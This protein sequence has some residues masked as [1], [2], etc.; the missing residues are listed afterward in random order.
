M[1]EKLLKNLKKIEK[2]LSNTDLNDAFSQIKS[3]LDLLPEDEVNNNSL[4]EFVI[5][6][7]ISSNPGS[8]VIYSDGACRGN[9]GPGAYGCIAQDSEA[10]VVFE[11]A[12]VSEQTTNNR[13][14]L[15][16]VIEGITTLG[17]LLN[18][19]GQ[20]ISDVDILVVTDSKYVVDGITKWMD[21]WKSRG[22]RKA[23]KKAPENVE[24]WQKLDLI[25]QK[26]GKRLS[27]DWV[28]GHAGH[29]QNEFC[30]QLANKALDNEGF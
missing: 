17:K 21:G 29:P 4:G 10:K 26:I 22:W 1:K 15:L 23:D 24:M 11:K 16:G 8:Y 27:V 18:E 20:S 9:P 19:K 28:K 7:S 6:S 30:D 14:E 3:A 25:K 5:P 12:A 13:M 2:T